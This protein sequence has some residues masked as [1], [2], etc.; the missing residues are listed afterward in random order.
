[1]P[2]VTL[3]T[4]FHRTTHRASIR[5]ADPDTFVPMQF[6]WPKQK[7]A[8][9]NAIMKAHPEYDVLKVIALASVE[10]RNGI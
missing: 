10:L 5:D 1:M 7:I 9:I 2:L 8:E 3:G 6:I 4:V